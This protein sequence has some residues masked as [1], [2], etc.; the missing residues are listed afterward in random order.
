MRGRSSGG[1]WLV[2][3]LGAGV[4]QLAGATSRLGAQGA[5]SVW[6]NTRSGVYHCAGTTY[7]GK[8]AQGEFLAEMAARDKGYR[9]NGG[10]A[11]GGRSAPPATDR[12]DASPSSLLGPIAAAGDDTPPS[13]PT[14]PTIECTVSRISDGDTI[15]CDALGKVRLIGLDTP[16]PDQEPYGSAATAALASFVPFGAVVLLE[17]DAEARDRYGRRLEYVWYKGR[18]VNWDLVRHGWG[19]T[20][21]YQPN[22]RYAALLDAAQ[23]RA[24]AEGR[25][26]WR[27]EGFRCQPKAH[28]ARE[29]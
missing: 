8:T 3:A 28:R 5:D 24:Q 27:I 16:E 22:V 15:E 23:A 17:S 13:A 6:V 10:R 26:L 19:V 12:P 9:A 11:C 4:M 21:H 7:F 14:G 2:V 29:C 25:G 1:R 18:M 20:L